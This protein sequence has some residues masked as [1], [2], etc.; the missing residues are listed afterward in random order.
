MKSM[1]SR[2]HVLG[3]CV[4]L[5]LLLGSTALTSS[6]EAQT[7]APPPPPVEVPAGGE[8]AAA[9][10]V[11]GNAAAVPAAL[12]ERSIV[13]PNGTLEIRQAGLNI[14]MSKDLA[15]KPI[16]LTIPNISFGIAEN[17]EIGIYVPGSAA[18][19]ALGGPTPAGAPWGNVQGL[20]LT[21]KENCNAGKRFNSIGV[22]G[23]Y[24]FLAGDFQLA[25]HGA[26]NFATL[27]DPMYAQLGVGVLGKYQTGIFALVFDPALYIGLTKRTEGTRDTNKESLSIPVSLQ[28]QAAPNVGVFLNT[29]IFGPTSH[30][31]DFYTVPVGIGG[32]FNLNPMLDLGATFTFNNLLGKKTPFLDESRADFRTLFV[33]V[34]I[35]PIA[36]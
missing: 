23:L 35:R 20:C 30:F 29:G 34:N 33:F 21:G 25:G 32:L 28:L 22:E 14:N 11:T 7:E 4:V 27:S 9:P 24:K 36:I 31:G 26:L 19:F 2:S 16:M 6:A 10:S 1:V 5:G 17:V 13:L 12:V 15:G 8:V 18:L 3:S